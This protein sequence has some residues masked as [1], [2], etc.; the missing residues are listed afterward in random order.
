MV[1][2]ILSPRNAIIS[3]PADLIDR[4]ETEMGPYRVAPDIQYKP[5]NE[6]EFIA[7]IYD[8]IHHHGRWALKL[9]QAE[10]V[11][12]LM[13]HFIAMDIAKHACGGSWTTTTRVTNL[14]I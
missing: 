1:T 10:P 5:G 2:D 12:V 4:Y 8:L 11:D 13:V 6:A 7:D 3:H 14:P 9:M